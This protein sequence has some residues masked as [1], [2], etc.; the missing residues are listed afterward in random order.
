MKNGYTLTK[1]WFEWVKTSD[2]NVRTIHT[3]LY[4]W[5]VEVN[6]RLEWLEVFGLNTKDAM[7]ATGIK[8]RQH[9]K[10]ALSD[11]IEWGHIILIKKAV[12]HHQSN[13]IS[14]NLPETLSTN[15]DDNS[16]KLVETLSTNKVELVETKGSKQTVLPETLSVNQIE[17]IPIIKNHKEKQE[18]KNNIIQNKREEATSLYFRILI[19]FFEE[20]RPKSKKTENDWID[21][22]DKLIRIDGKTCEEIE[23]VIIKTRADDFWRQNFLSVLKL[24]KRNKEGILY[25][26]VFQQM[27]SKKKKGMTDL[28]FAQLIARLTN[29]PEAQEKYYKEHPEFAPA[30]INPID[31]SGYGKMTQKDREAY[32]RKHPDEA[33]WNRPKNGKSVKS[34]RSFISNPWKG[35]TM[36]MRGIKA[37]WPGREVRVDDKGLVIFRDDNC[38]PLFVDGKNE[39][40]EEM[41]EYNGS[42]HNEN[43]IIYSTKIH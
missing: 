14:I 8:G 40:G 35:Q 5:I 1:N 37:R 12:N 41:K 19:F 17:I 39:N 3:A 26:T 10:N 4:L 7:K 16:V 11:L 6:N 36:T 28:E 42:I 22:L 15:K 20:L 18:K 9:Y 2:M 34:D 27:E 25:F 43:G 30:S 32:E 29:T 13:L 31:I 33:F 24:R 38:L 23:S 21:C